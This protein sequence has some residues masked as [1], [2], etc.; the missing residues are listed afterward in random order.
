MYT[1]SEIMPVTLEV[2]T[3]VFADDSLLLTETT[4]LPDVG[5]FDSL[6]IVT[7]LETLE[8]TLGIEAEPSRLLPEAFETPR[9]IAELFVES[10]KTSEALK[11][12]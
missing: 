9:K 11:R 2:V 6:R 10:Q 3:K 5:G 1:L 7:I 8:A 4:Y 12:E